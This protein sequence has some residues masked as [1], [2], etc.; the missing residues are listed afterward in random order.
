MKNELKERYIYAVCRHLP[1]KMQADV[2]KELGGLISEM[3][4]ERTANRTADEDD[5]K[6][7]LAELGAPEEL[8]LKY[9]DN[10][11]TA[12]ISGAYYLTYMHVL[13]LVL[14]IVVGGMLGL[15]IIGQIFNMGD[16]IDINMML[17]F[18]ITFGFGSI[19]QI[20]TG[21]IGA[22]ITAFAIITIIFAIMEYK[23]TDL[24]DGDILSSLPDVPDEKWRISRGET[25]FGII[26]SV[27]VVIVLLGYPHIFSARMDGVWIPVFD[28]DVLRGLWLPI[29]TWAVFGIFAEIVALIEGRYTM[30]LAT[31]TLIANVVIVLCAISIFA[32]D[33]IMNPDFLNFLDITLADFDVFI[34]TDALARG[35]LVLLGII[36]IVAAAETIVAFVKAILARQ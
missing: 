8:A 5:L 29:I 34:L 26:M 21:A 14:P 3:L 9:C 25:L 6:A 33:N 22:G 30:R 31:V 28:I 4:D 18:N 1:A 19:I 7:V 13:R 23:K 10:R 11:R 17:F 36:I 2:S 20:I 15:G 27:A 24:H 12:L 16:V 35:H 32:G